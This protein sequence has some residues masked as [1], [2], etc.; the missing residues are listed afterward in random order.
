MRRHVCITGWMPPIDSPRPGSVTSIASAESLASSSAATSASRRD[1][2]NASIA[3]FRDVDARPLGLLQRRFEL[4][5]R[6]QALGDRT[7]LAEKA[8]L[9]VLERRPV[10]GG[11]EA[12][13]G[14][15]HQPVEVDGQG[16]RK[17]FEEIGHL[18]FGC[19]DR[20][21]RAACGTGPSPG[22]V[23]SRVPLT[24]LR[25]FRQPVRRPRRRRNE[26]VRRWP[27]T[28]ACPS[29]PCRPAPCGPAR[30]TPS[31]GRR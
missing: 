19:A 27:R 1:V 30:S 11:G 21:V 25:C 5:E 8:R 17:R 20:G 14:V 18:D 10:D 24:R 15:A 13:G 6:L 3:A 16:V 7:R 29:P 23:V 2:S 28:P 9:L 12:L 26:P 31:S 4:A 22:P